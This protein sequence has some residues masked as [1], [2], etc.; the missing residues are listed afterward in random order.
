[1]TQI[2]DPLD[3]KSK[4]VK[5]L[6]HQENILSD[7]DFLK[8]VHKRK[9]TK[10]ILIEEEDTTS[11]NSELP[12]NDNTISEQSLL[13]MISKQ[14]LQNLLMFLRSSKV[15]STETD[16]CPDWARLAL[17]STNPNRKPRIEYY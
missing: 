7:D 2:L 15:Q 6:T 17:A 1:M 9:I 10:I 16:E 5:S 14:D 11:D 12:K 4:F 8:P 13:K 3:A